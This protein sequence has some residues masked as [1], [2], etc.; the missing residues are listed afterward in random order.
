LEQELLP[1]LQSHGAAAFESVEAGEIVRG[2][3]GVTSDRGEGLSRQNLVDAGLRQR[4]SR[5]RAD[6]RAG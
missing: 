1:R 4:R 5:E 6:E 2:D 3:V